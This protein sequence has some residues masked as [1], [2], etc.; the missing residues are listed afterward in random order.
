MAQ[1]YN[2]TVDNG[3]YIVTKTGRGDQSPVA[4]F[5]S[6]DSDVADSYMGTVPDVDGDPVVYV[7][8]SGDEATISDVSDVHIGALAAV[9][10]FDVT[11]IDVPVHTVELSSNKKHRF[12]DFS[13]STP[14][15]VQN[16]AEI[17]A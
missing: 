8:E 16:P 3:V 7:G 10:A 5:K 15:T 2:V 13:E 14:V 9:D 4:V 6:V 17:P 1:T 12:M 11:I